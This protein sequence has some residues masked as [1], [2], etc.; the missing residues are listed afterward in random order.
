MINFSKRH[1]PIPRL[2]TTFNKNTLSTNI[3]NQGQLILAERVHLLFHQPLL[4]I[5]LVHSIAVIITVI[6]LWKIIAPEK[7]LAWAA[8]MIVMTTIWVALI[9]IYRH[10]PPLPEKIKLWLLV[11]PTAGVL[12][13]SAWGVTSL[14]PQVMT[15]PSIT[16]FMSIM[17]LGITAAGLAVL[18]PILPAFFAYVTLAIVPFAIQFF[19]TGEQLHNTLGIMF[20]IYLFVIMLSGYNMKRVVLESITLRFE[21]LMLVNDLVKKNAQTERAREEAIQAGIEKSKFIATASHDLRQPLHALRLFI[22][23]LE[24]RISYPEVRKIVD[25]IK[26]ATGTLS[27]LMNEMLDISKLDAGI[28]HPVISD[29]PIQPLLKRIAVESEQDA[30]KKNLRFKVRHCPA[31]VH[32]DQSMLERILRNLITNAIHYTSH[33]NVLVTCRHRNSQLCIEVRDSG[34]GITE[35]ELTK[36]FNDFYQVANSERDRNKGYG[37]GLAIVERLAKLLNHTISVNSTPGKGSVFCICLPLVATTSANTGAPLSPPT[38]LD[39][40][41]GATILVIDDEVLILEGMKDILT[42]WGCDVLIADSAETACTQLESTKQLPDVIISDYRLRDNKTGAQAIELIQQKTHRI[43][44]AIIVTGDTS[45]DRLHEI[46]NSGYQ[47]LHKP[48]LP[49]KLRSLLSYLLEA[50]EQ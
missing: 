40:V 32:S 23:A 8:C 9:L 44:P 27:N 7:L 19:I 11:F 41:A 1:T 16:I 18:A 22:E 35:N 30:V 14:W 45:T 4:S 25:N 15:M 46:R 37:L 34:I 48:V 2:K 33:G 12:M 24:L 3:S 42:K 6:F 47:L 36:I 29:F 39:D 21:N 13:G 50:R 43:F 31:V 10:R 38:Y 5:L 28:L 49:G 20:L 17:V 26:L